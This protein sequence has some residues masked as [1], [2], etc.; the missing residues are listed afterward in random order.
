M[1]VRNAWAEIDLRAVKHNVREAK[2]LSP[3]TKLCAVVKADAYGHG[4]VP[5]ATA[6]LEAGAEFLA[7]AIFSEALE[8][9]TS[10]IIKVPILILGAPQFEYI[11]D[12]IK[13]DISQTVFSLEQAT[14]LSIEAVKLG[15]KAKIHLAIE[16]GMN[17]IGIDYHQAGEIAKAIYD[18]PNIVVQGCF[19]HFAT[20]DSVDKGYAYQQFAKFE[21]ALADIKQAGIN[22]EYRHMAN[23]AAISEMPEMKLD[24]VRQGI[25]LY[26]IWPSAEV[27]RCASFQPV[28][29]LK[30]KIVWLK[31]IEADESIGYGRTFRTK[32]KTTVATL[33]LGYADGIRRSLSNKGYVMIRGQKAPIVGRV[34]MDQLMVDV[35]DIPNVALQDEAII[36]GDAEL[37]IEVVA[38]WCETI[39]YEILC[40]ISKRVPRIYRD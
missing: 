30:A 23:S 37:P 7:V 36:F 1:Y 9:R 28:M 4:A 27:E 20:A 12:I 16:T 26:G 11:E 39:P 34:C 2:K 10:K 24:M 8:L 21:Q 17:R 33:P 14:L 6:A 13:Y 22:L 15:K 29:S 3:N 32:R 19:S 25:T 18:L 38:D 35:T 31:E 40:N 5:V